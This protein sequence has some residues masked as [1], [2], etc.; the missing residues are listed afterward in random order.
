MKINDVNEQA[1]I[2]MFMKTNVCR[3]QN[4]HE[5]HTNQKDETFSSNEY[6]HEEIT[7]CQTI[8]DQRINQKHSNVT[9]KQPQVDN[10]L[11]VSQFYAPIPISNSKVHFGPHYVA[12]DASPVSTSFS[13]TSSDTE[14][15]DS[16]SVLQPRRSSQ[17]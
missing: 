9:V 13:A 8:E 5:L 7:M 4:I 1:P 10:M 17:K 3:L 11:G 15:S 14:H 16:A 12:G 6:K 2:S